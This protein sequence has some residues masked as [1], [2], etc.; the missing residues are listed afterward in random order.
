[1][2]KWKRGIDF[3]LLCLTTEWFTYLTARVSTQVAA[4]DEEGSIEGSS[5]AT[6]MLHDGVLV[7]TKSGIGGGKWTTQ[8]E[9]VEYVFGFAFPVKKQQICQSRNLD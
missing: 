2:P 6:E 1:M 5:C 7:D 9:R 4:I 3:Y 8:T